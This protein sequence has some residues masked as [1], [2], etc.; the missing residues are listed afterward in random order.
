MTKKIIKKFK[1]LYFF[2]LFFATLF[3]YNSV[4]F[5]ALLDKGVV[6][7]KMTKQESAFRLTSGYADDQA[8]VTGVA[9]VISKVIKGFLGLLGIIFIILLIVA[10]QKWMTAGGEEEKVNEA[11]DTIKRAIIGLIIV[12]AA[13]SITYFVFKSL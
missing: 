8:T 11:K 5:G 4:C 7:D 2:L 10:G 9:T 1:L 12:V 6:T 3:S 13:Y